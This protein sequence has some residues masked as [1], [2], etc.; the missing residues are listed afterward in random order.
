MR[1]AGLAL[2]AGL[3]FCFGCGGGGGVQT[4]GEPVVLTYGDLGGM[5]AEY[6]ADLSVTT[7]E[8]SR[9]W[10]SSFDFSMSVEELAD[11]GGIKRR[12]DFD[13]FAVTNYSGSTPEP[14]PN[15]GEYSGE[16]LI[17]E[18]NAEGS[19]IDWRGLDGIKGGTPGGPRFKF[20]L[21]YVMFRM[22]QP[23]PAN[24]VTVG[25]TWQG[26]FET[27]VRMAGNEVAMKGTMDYEV[28]GYGTRAGRDCV[29]I[30]T[31]IQ[32]NGVGDRM[33]GDQNEVS[34]EHEEEGKGEIW[35]DYTNG[36]IVEFTSNSTANQTYRREIAGKTDVTTDHSGVDSEIK[37]KMK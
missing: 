31:G 12:F 11:D 3:I 26:S 18:Q 25:T 5:P 37:I 7:G 20:L 32:I 34:F 4:T 15:A 9:N 1:F 29:K 17:L 14:D 24:Q 8:G 19:I 33:V 27:P 30:K 10:I 36:V 6:E 2:L 22:H 21:V 13:N 23:S 16:F 35:W 28:V